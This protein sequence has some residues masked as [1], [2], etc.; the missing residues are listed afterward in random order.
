MAIIDYAPQSG[1]GYEPRANIDLGRETA[2]GVKKFKPGNVVRV[3]LLGSIDSMSFSKP[4]DPGEGG[5]EGHLTLKVQKMEIL[6]SAKNE[7]AELLD[8]DE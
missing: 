1:D 6:D 8:D 3:V 7:I 2:K 4:E 5:F